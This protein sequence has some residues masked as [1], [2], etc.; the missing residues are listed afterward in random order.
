MQAYTKYKKMHRYNAANETKEFFAPYTHMKISFLEKWNR[1]IIEEFPFF[2]ATYNAT[3][4]N[5]HKVPTY[6]RYFLSLT[7]TVFLDFLQYSARTSREV[8]F[9]HFVIHWET[10]KLIFRSR[11]LF[12]GLYSELKYDERLIGKKKNYYN[13][14]LSELCFF[15]KFWFTSNTN[16]E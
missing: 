3:H 15:P 5:A 2:R 14:C 7:A 11:E 12:H 4:I 10:E 16:T 8:C 1:Y 9:L 6:V 13:V